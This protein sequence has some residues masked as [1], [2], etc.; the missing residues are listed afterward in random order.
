MFGWRDR[1]KST[2]PTMAQEMFD[3]WQFMKLYEEEKKREADAVKAKKKPEIRFKIIDVVLIL[4]GTSLITGP[5]GH[6]G[7]VMWS[8]W[9]LDT[10]KHLLGTQ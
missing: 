4:I 6:V 3:M 10:M 2:E 1:G 7:L 5:L 9:Y 8:Q